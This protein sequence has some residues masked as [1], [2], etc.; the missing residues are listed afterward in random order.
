M[1]VSR[2]NSD[3]LDFSEDYTMLLTYIINGINQLYHSIKDQFNGA[4]E[5]VDYTK[6]TQIAVSTLYEQ[7]NHSHIAITKSLHASHNLV[8]LTGSKANVLEVTGY[9]TSKHQ[10]SK[11][12]HPLYKIEAMAGTKNIINQQGAIAIEQRQQIKPFLSEAKFLDATYE[13]SRETFHTL[14]QQWQEECS[15]Q[16]AMTFYCANII[17]LCVLGI[18][19]LS[20]EEAKL[21]RQAGKVIGTESI[22]SP[23]FT[24][25]KNK[26]DALNT[27]TVTRYQNHIIQHENY[28]K[29]KAHLNADDSSITQQKKLLATH[30]ASNLL[31]ESNLSTLI[32][33]GIY[34][35]HQS[36]EIYEKL[37]HEIQAV[38][39]LDRDKIQKLP[40]LDRIYKE[41]LRYISPTAVI[42]RESS[43]DI[44]VDVQDEKNAH[45]THVI[46]H[47]AL[48]FAPIRRIHHDPALWQDPET[49][50]PDRFQYDRCEQQLLP[51]SLGTRSC[52]AAAHFNP[53]VFKTALVA[54]L[55]YRYEFDKL[56]E[57]IPVDAISSRW[58]NE[59][60][61]TVKHRQ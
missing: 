31:V 14:M 2:Y 4:T 60:Y 57:T 11:S 1:R 35:V 36:K 18:P 32:M 39:K 44:T 7:A 46:Q 24:T 20:M 25:M 9:G 26:L 5:P 19:Q 13:K 48:L 17:G 8:M 49:F 12:R 37:A 45:H 23:T 3:T 28:I 40:Y 58:N 61:A 56:L 16:D 43:R 6:L 38:D 50:N 55:K 29:E 51:F 53:I 34:Y 59:Y 52:P 27:A 21:I 47:P 10:D 30:G 15:F 41:T 42:V 54:S 22:E 33:A